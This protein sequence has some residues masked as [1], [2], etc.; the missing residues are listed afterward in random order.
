LPTPIDHVLSAV[1]V[2]VPSLAERDVDEAAARAEAVPCCPVSLGRLLTWSV[3]PTCFKLDAP[4]VVRR[5]GRLSQRSPL[6]L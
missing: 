3:R 2:T 4:M 5:S 1:P 6:G